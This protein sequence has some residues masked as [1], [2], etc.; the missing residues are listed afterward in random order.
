MKYALTAKHSLLFCDLI[1]VS[2]A[3]TNYFKKT[4]NINYKISESLVRDH[5]V[6]WNY[7]NDSKYNDELLKKRTLNQAVNHFITSL[8]SVTSQLENVATEISESEKMCFEDK[9]TLTILFKKYYHTYLLNMPF[10]YSYW[11]TEHLIIS[12]LKKD[13]HKIF[14]KNYEAILR[15]LLIPAHHTY[16]EKE[17][18]HMKKIVRYIAGN[19]SLKQKIT[20]KNSLIDD[21]YLD[22]LICNHIANFSFTATA[23]YLGKPLDKKAVLERI[24]MCL[25]DFSE[26]ENRK[27]EKD[28]EKESLS[29]K[30]ILTKLDIYPEVKERLQIAC[31]LLY[32]K[33]QRLDI[34]FK[35][36]FLINPLLQTLATLMGISFMQLVHLRYKEIINWFDT[37]ELPNKEDINKR[38]KSYSLYLKAGKITLLT[39]RSKYLHLAS[40]Q[41]NQAIQFKKMIKG[42]VARR[43]KVTGQVRLVFFSEDIIRVKKGEILVTTMTRP[44]MIV[45]MEKAAA[46]VTDQGGMLSH[47]AII[48]REMGKPCIVGTKIA[49]HILKDGDL[50]E[51]DAEKGIVKLLK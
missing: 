1:L 19:I 45:G 39:D 33:N 36:D 42:T 24:K 21:P 51:V 30:N 17:K 6:F 4:L 12:Q 43:G 32:W 50:V 35:S 2:V 15:Q 7:D 34:L 29:R 5:A 13:F 48:A 8:N 38:I 28:R 41:S 44:D 31:E 3:G 14:G 22:Y 49:T 26:E 23:F 46:F 16:F 9:Q 47:A 11:N 10:L 27:K 37:K 25:E 18:R 20:A 40:E